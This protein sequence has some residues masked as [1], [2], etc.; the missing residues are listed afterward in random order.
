[1]THLNFILV[2]K[3]LWNACIGHYGVCAYAF[4]SKVS[5]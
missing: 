5:K 1:M 2:G 4:G 3:I